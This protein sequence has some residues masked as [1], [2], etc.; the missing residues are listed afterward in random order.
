MRQRVRNAQYPTRQ[1]TCVTSPRIS[2]VR[3]TWCVRRH[4]YKNIAG[5][6]EEV[7]WWGRYRSVCLLSLERCSGLRRRWIDGQ[8]VGCRLWSLEET[9]ERQTSNWCN[10]LAKGVSVHGQLQAQY[11]LPPRKSPG[12][13]STRGWVIR[14]AGQDGCGEEKISCPHQGSKP[15]PSSSYLVTIPVPC[16]PW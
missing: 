4:G 16:L 12:T 14:E 2:R 11:A 7:V 6:K 10:G 1:N 3:C 8:E 9:N 5:G 15:K 13:C